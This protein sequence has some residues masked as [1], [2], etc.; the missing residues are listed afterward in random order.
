MLRLIVDK[1]D[2][3]IRESNLVI[4]FQLLFDK[5]KFDKNINQSI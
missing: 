5:T 4:N 2:V 3:I 1:Y